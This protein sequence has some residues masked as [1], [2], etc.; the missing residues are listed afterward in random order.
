MSWYDAESTA[1]SLGGHLVAINDADENNWVAQIFSGTYGDIWI[2]A[3]DI[4]KGIESFTWTSGDLFSYSNWNGGEPSNSGGTEWV[5]EMYSNSSHTWNDINPGNSRYG[6]IE[7]SDTKD[8]DGDGWV[9]VL[10]PYPSDAL[11]VFDLR[12]PGADGVFDTADDVK[13]Q[14]SCGDYSRG[15]SATFNVIDGPL[16]PG[17]YRFKVTTSLKD[18]FGNALATPYVRYFTNIAVN[19]FV[20]Q[21]RRTNGVS[22]TSLSLAQGSLGD[23]SF[24]LNSSLSLGNNPYFV[25]SG[26]FN[27][28]G[29]LDLVFANFGDHTV[30]VA[31]NDSTGHFSI[32]T[33]ITLDSGTIS[34]GVG[35]FDADSKLDL[36]VANYYAGTVSILKGNGAGGFT[37]FTNISGFS[38]PRNLEVADFNKDG[39]LDFAVPNENNSSVS[40]L[41]GAGGGSFTN[42][43]KYTVGSSPETV[44][45]GD[46]NGDGYLDLVVPNSGSATFSVLM[47]SSD[48]SFTL[49][50][51][52]STVSTPRYAALAD[53]N[54][55][56]K[57]DVVLV[58]N[59][60]QL[61]VYP[62]N[63][64]GSFGTRTDYN[65]SSGDTYQ[66][67]L[68]DLNGDGKL[69]VVVPAYGA[70]RLMTLLNNGDGTFGSQINYNPGNYPISAVVG[71]FNKDGRLDIVTANY[72]GA[73]SWIL[74]GNNRQTLA[75]DTAGT[76]LRLA[77][78]RGNIADSSDYDYWTFS[79]AT[80][81]RLLIGTEAPG[82]PYGSSLLY[83]IYYPDGGQ[84]TYFY[85]DGYGRGDAS[86]TIP[87][88][89][90][91]TI[92]VERSQNYSGEYRF[93]VTLATPPAQLESEDNS[94]IANA[95]VLTYTQ[96][97]GQRIASV[98]GY[99]GN[100]DGNG[101]Y[102]QLG[103]L[104]VGT[105]IT[106]NWARPSASHLEPILEIYN[107][108]GVLVT[109]TRPDQTNL[110]FMVDAGLGGAYYAH[111]DS[112]LASRK[113][114]VTNA[115]YFN[116][117]STYINIGNWSPGTQWSMQAWVMP[118]DLP[119]GRR[120]VV[121]GVGG[122]RD[123]AIVLNGGYFAADV[124]LNGC[125][126]YYTS[127]T[128]AS[129]YTWYHLAISCD[130]TNAY[131][132]V[133]GQMIASGPVDLNFAPYPGGTWIGGESC[134][135]GYF[136]GIIQDVSIWSRP[137]S[138]AEVNAFMAN[139]PVGTES[140]LAGLWSLQDGNGTTVPDLSGNGH[141]GT[142][143][144]GLY[145]MTLSST[146][147]LTSGLFQQ[148]LLN[149]RLMNTIAPA[150]VD[151]NL[152]A[153]GAVSSNIWDRF[154][155]TFSE[156][157]SPASVTNSNNYDLRGAGPDGTFGTADDQIYT[158]INSPAY[159]SGNSA[160]FYA[161]D[162]P[163]QP[164]L[165][166][167]TVKESVTDPLGTT[168]NAPYVR[169]FSVVN[170][171]GFTYEN[172]GDNSIGKATSLSSVRT[173][174]ADGAFTAGA[175]KTM[176]TG[177]E[178]LA[179][180][181]I[182]GDSNLD[183]I[184]ALWGYGG[185][186]VL[187]GNGDG[188]FTVKTNYLTGSQA[189]SVAL[190]KFNAD[191]NLDVAV[192]NYGSGTI[193]ILLGNGDGTF[194]AGS[195]Y[196]VG[197]NPYHVV[198]ADLNGDGK[199]DLIV[200]NRGSGKVSI[201]L[202]NGDGTFQT[203]T[204]YTVGSAP[205][206]VAVADINGDGKLDLFVANYNDNNVSLLLGKG[207]GTFASPIEIA[208]GT[209]PRS[210]AVG[211]V[212]AD[213]KLD[214]L[215]FNGGDNN[216]SVYLGNG[217][218]SFAS[219]V[220]YIAG[221]YDG[222][223]MLLQDVNGDGLPDIVIPGYNNSTLNLLFNA[224]GGKFASPASYPIGYY[225]V[226]IV[227]G[228]FNNDGRLD[229]V[230][231]NDYGNSIS[232]LYGN[233]TQLLSTDSMTGLRIG[234][235]RGNL[236][237]SSQADYWSFDAQQ[238]DVF[239]LAT[240]V[241]GNPSGSGLYFTIY[242]PDGR[243]LTSFSADYYGR[244]QASATCPL[245]GTYTVR[246]SPNYNYFGEYRIRVTLASPPIQAESEGND[247]AYYAN[248]LSYTVTNNHQ[249]A[250]VLGYYSSADGGDFFKLGTLVSGSSINLSLTQ[251]GS[252]GLVGGM[253]ITDPAGNTLAYSKERGT[254]LTFTVST[255]GDYYVDVWGDTTAASTLALGGTNGYALRFWGGDWISFTNAEIPSS[256][257]FTVECWAYAT[258]SSGYREII[259]QGTGGNAFYLGTDGSR[260]RSGDSWQNTGVSYPF[261][262]WHHFAI[263]K[264]SSST[265]LYVDGALA[266]TLGSA[267]AN[268]VM[269]EGFR[270]G[271]QYGGYSEQWLGYIDDVR[272]WNVARSAADISSNFTNRLSGAESGLVGYWRFDE[273]SGYTIHDST[274]AGATGTFNGTLVWVPFMTNAQTPNIFAQYLLGIDVNNA[275]PLTVLSN[276]L[277]VAS[278]TNGNII[279]RFTVYFPIDLNT[280]ING[281][282]RDIRL[283]NG[284]AYTVTSG[285]CSWYD[286]ETQARALGGHLVAINDAAENE[287]L[288]NTFGSYGYFWIGLNDES[289]E[290]TWTW[291][292]GDALV[293]SNWD[294]G[295]PGGTT[296]DYAFLR[297]DNS[298]WST[299]QVNYSS[300]YGV[301][302]ITGTDTDGDGIPDSLDPYPND[303]YNG[304]DLRTAGK[305]GLFDTSD[306]EI[307]H[308]AINN[309]STGESL[310]ASVTDGPLQ[311]GYYRFT[312]TKSLKDVFG[313]SLS[314]PYVQYFTV[315]NLAGYV[316][317]SRTNNTAATATPL[318]WN[319]ELTGF[320]TVAARG[321]MSTSSD[322]DYYSFSGAAGD[323]FNIASYTIGSPSGSELHYQVFKTNG[324]RIVDFYP[325]Y[326][327]NGE[328]SS[329][330]LPES[331]TY[332][333]SV[334]SYYDYQ[335]EYRFR[336]TTGTPPLQ[337]E[338]EAN[339]TIANANSLN[340]TSDTNGRSVSV[341]GRIRIAS[342]LDYY[343]LGTVTNG[344]S[345]ILN[346]RQP[347]T[348]GL[349][350]VVSVYNASGVYQSEIYGGRSSD[351]VANV[352]IT[353]TGVYY[354][355][356]RGTGDS[357][358]MDDQYVLDVNIVPTGSVNYP[359]LVV[360]DITP[361]S[362]SGILSGQKVAYT[363]TVANIGS[364]AT[365]SSA[366]MDRA[367]FSQDATLGNG[368]D[369]AVGFFSHSG[370][371]NS[372]ASYTVT[373]LFTLPDGISG[374]FY[375]IVQTDSGSAVNEYM[376]DGDNTTVSTTTFHVSLAPYPDLTIENLNISNPTNSAYTITWNVANRGNGTAPGGFYGRYIV[377]DKIS[378]VV[379]TNEETV[380]TNTLATNAV[381]SFVRT[382]SATNSGTYLVQVIA[383]S[384][385]T[386]YEYNS[387]G[388]A[389]A[390]TNNTATA[391]FQIMAYYN[392]ALQ[393]NPTNAGVLSGAGKFGSGTAVT[394]TATPAT[395]TLP[396]IFVNWT[397]GGSFQSAGTNYTFIISRDRSLT[398]NFTLPTYLVSASVT[399]AGAGIVS[400]Q[401]SFMYGTT[402]VLTA[403]A[404]YGYRFSNWT[405]N[406]TVISQNASLTNVVL[407]NRTFI[408]NFAEANVTHIVT[409]MTSPTN[410]TTVAGAGTY[411]NGQSAVISA[412]AL[413][414]NPPTIY[415]FKEFQL[416][417]TVVSSSPSFTKTFSTLDST[418][419]T[420]VA[421]YDSVS[422]LPVITNVTVNYSGT[423]PATT[424]A[425]L[426]F[427]FDRSMNTNVTPVILITNAFASKQPQ[428]PAGGTW[429]KTVL[430]NDTFAL[431]PV[432]FS[433][434]MDG[435]NTVWV[436]NARDISGGILTA[437]NLMKLI[438]DATPPV[439]P[440]LSLTA[441]NNASATVSWSS[442]VAPSDLNGFRIFISTNSFTSVTGLV[443]VSAV[444][445]STRS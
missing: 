374:D 268:P 54:G 397:E 187:L 101:D 23:A 434:G 348:S 322:N 90:T 78:G 278:T 191:T 200:P 443:P 20:E 244:G 309:Y 45:S 315:T 334:S 390:E 444:A 258:A 3:N 429:S 58:N 214:L 99:I 112:T 15:L 145:W 425:I 2:G 267:I 25:N 43:T 401:G 342:D 326:Y 347:A 249:K 218:G 140:G 192:A 208:A 406:G 171:P 100:A 290:N 7:I 21:N 130:G 18:R 341:I 24:S 302:E 399:P 71:D 57:L 176:G 104:G 234:A 306:D 166:R 428:T 388:H 121:G 400:G 366:W 195:N 292:S 216:V 359:N 143:V 48:G 245:T 422:I 98:G 173:N 402:N 337:M 82:D 122:C 435:T 360:S 55:D 8:T 272:V 118:T 33:N 438:V 194:K 159:A 86:L 72:Y 230:L 34:I 114:G 138:G 367:V 95:D 108:S 265:L 202:G 14:I 288:V 59:G 264:S 128:A 19:G 77:A 232:I 304:F 6:V 270:I 273:G 226:G 132:Y 161:P 259:S 361:P 333:I 313:N 89:G 220:N 119:S 111:V 252:S 385:D 30:S 408:A 227:C 74:F 178:R 17:V 356:V 85:S 352:P 346:V 137:L 393:S 441:S 11:N 276:N 29:H 262:G 94:S 35:D 126:T 123:W 76:G 169:N 228:D 282:N 301:I 321:N 154:T 1:I 168:M 376:F 329:V 251:P 370:I 289:K 283:Y 75:L 382:F 32:S 403:S 37:L 84:W 414:T 308:I 217:D 31:T 156:D 116:A 433:T 439:N 41:F 152:P 105:Q 431:P 201:L 196:N 377:S 65:I 144:N 237:D 246:V 185:V 314:T 233:D 294:N 164:G 158:V 411:N 299:R 103:N 150:V 418:N 12:T 420:Y 257:D 147:S 239:A 305:D 394:V 247:S 440:V 79:A 330:T 412:P 409:T 205:S 180:G 269:G 250:T 279:D 325:S 296:Y 40:I 9:D 146:N 363:F 351:G 67:L 358:D 274:S 160:T 263:V 424:N 56:G 174:R 398:A 430:S 10:D 91:Y 64:D 426:T 96:T 117:S 383:D 193:S 303:P 53:V 155:V 335:G 295:Q 260:I 69:D 261:Y 223:D 197:S 319:E 368:D 328:S 198:V 392:V 416:S 36:A 340:F 139:S 97:N 44:R 266:A 327:G 339:D 73:N 62:G 284:R 183:I 213:G 148:Y 410:V 186:G 162:G 106:L 13:Y 307:Y 378:G 181:K 207:D 4:A 92:R 115:L 28:D 175:D 415:K 413:V 421:V 107:S 236:Y 324:T 317:E 423:I 380:V 241:P 102:Y 375:V 190:G 396:Y 316:L 80:G 134:C 203:K 280:S 93:R 81:D 323:V 124:G 275:T 312:V 248:T 373:N 318:A 70:S 22:T 298:K 379:L 344:S 215:V 110:V 153:E 52:Y 419:L 142:L 405:E 199:Q 221:T 345:I 177:V 151:V 47:G 291:S 120:T 417:G 242:R 287:W 231:G 172:R 60:N 222:Y 331:G 310:S 286:A 184:A 364:V 387:Y 255:N 212:N 49:T 188:T 353:T 16:Q 277:P 381:V 391:T 68:A 87:A 127:P 240:E 63:G 163:I 206:Y 210:L 109:N 285:T 271:R 445:T 229:F 350:P 300:Y 38:Y 42:A 225:P 211:D 256:G 338:T 349:V 238:N 182:D 311:P 141:T 407:T 83:R 209:S 243:T 343:N 204:D 365:A 179:V 5:G 133:N 219:R 189:W 66:V 336:I 371:L 165:V 427:R 354:A 167:F 235:G 320:K 26:D 136:P 369:I 442:Y 149:V 389:A 281:I 404:N 88:S 125:V 384:R 157:M 297:N 332:T 61:S 355:L 51:N 437:T 386:V 436:S 372:G 224:G 395:N 113:A 253:S 357:G 135:G 129:T 254:N 170:V 131:F 293:Y 362:G 432:T 27:K 50:T 39:I 46:L